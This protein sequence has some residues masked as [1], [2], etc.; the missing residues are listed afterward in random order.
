MI[1]AWDARYNVPEYIFGTEPNI[2]LQQQVSRLQAGQH[3]L[4]VA[5]GE[6]RNGVWL[7][8]QGLLVD[9]V[10]SSA[11]AQSKARQLAESRKVDI[12]FIHADLLNWDWGTARYDAVVGIFI[13]FATGAGRDAMFAGIKAATKSGGLVLLQGYTPRQLQYKTGGPPGAENMYTPTILQAYFADWDILLL[14]EHDAEINEGA[15]HSGMSALIDL[16]ARKR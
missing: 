7:A 14:K 9:A 10:D 5:D 1:G 8:Q 12:N 3:V 11:V 13:Q 2:F 15:H 4:A 16:V 6:G